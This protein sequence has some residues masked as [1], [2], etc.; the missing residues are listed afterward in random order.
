V[1]WVTVLGSSQAQIDYRLSKA[2]GCDQVG[3]RLAG[4]GC[5]E[6]GDGEEEAGRG[7][8]WVG[9]GLA[10]L[11]VEGMVAGEPLTAEQRL[12]RP[13]DAGPSRAPPVGEGPLTRYERR[14]W[15]GTG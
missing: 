3:Y 14:L 15:R 4:D 2:A 13:T 9:A 6:L 5:G 12:D 11:G 10:E 1:A 8:M 7:L